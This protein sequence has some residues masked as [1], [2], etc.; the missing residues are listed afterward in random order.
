[1]QL[2][3][4]ET[5]DDKYRGIDQWP[6]ASV[7]DAIAEAQAQAVASVKAVIP[8]IAAAADD[9]AARLRGGTGR[10]VYCGA[11]TSIRLAVQDG[12]E[13]TP[14]YGWP[15]RRLGFVIAGGEGALL[16]PVE[17]AED[18]MDEGTRAAR[19]LK[20]DASDVCVCVSASGATPFTLAA[21]RA[22]KAQG[23]LTV[24]IASNPDVPL[25]TEAAYG[26]FLDSGPEPVAGSTRMNA[27]TA[28]KVALN[29]L[30]TLIMIR[31]GHV[32]DG[33]MVDML[34]TNAKLRRRA[35]RMVA[36]IT[37]CPED[38]AAQA[39]GRA[40]D[41]I[42][43]AVLIVKGANPEDGRRLLRDQGGDLRRALIALG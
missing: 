4:T 32:Y 40:G 38:A 3:R 17:G 8:V 10:M 39:L 18:D 34:P 21:M 13:L 9:A 37:G 20:L 26:L 27:G 12:S 29:M 22:A 35:V 23:A 19:A 6:A 15:A 11:G 30:S 36:E 1:M 7:L 24:G 42:K 43:L 14:T 16:T 25:A 41:S 28:Q 31:L 5:A 33:R 2:T